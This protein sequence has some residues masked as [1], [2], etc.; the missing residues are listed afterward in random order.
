MAGL[1]SLG[2]SGKGPA[3]TNHMEVRDRVAREDIQTERTKVCWGNLRSPK[4]IVISY[5]PSVRLKEA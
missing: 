3:T 2:C 5:L 4:F 1:I